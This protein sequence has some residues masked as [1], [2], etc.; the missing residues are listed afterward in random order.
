L[1]WTPDR[2]KRLRTRLQMTQQKFSEL[3]GVSEVTVWRWEAG[4][5]APSGLAQAGLDAVLD[6]K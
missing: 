4:I 2:I 3:V 6:V 5:T 1:K